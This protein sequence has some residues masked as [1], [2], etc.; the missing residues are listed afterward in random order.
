MIVEEMFYGKV[1]VLAKKGKLVQRNTT[2]V[3]GML[4]AQKIQI[5]NACLEQKSSSEFLNFPTS[6]GRIKIAK[7]CYSGHKNCTPLCSILP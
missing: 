4:G 2:Q 7:K 6:T 1:V 5:Y 3:R